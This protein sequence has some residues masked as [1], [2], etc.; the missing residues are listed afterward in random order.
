MERRWWTLLVVCAAMFMLLID[1]N[2]VVVALPNIQ[3]A[4]DAS[5]GSL[6]WMTDA[7]ALTL[8]ALLL[9][10]G[11]LADTYG[12]R[13]AFA[14]GLVVFTGGSLLCGLSPSAPTLVLFRAVQGC[15][16][17]ILSA[18]S[19]ALLAGSFHGRQRGVAFGVWGAVAGAATGLGPVLG[20]VLTDG[21]GWRGIF[22][23]N[24]PVGIA[25]LVI[26]VCRVDESRA[27]RGGRIDWPGVVTL[28]A[29]LFSLVYGLITAS[30]AGWRERGV[31]LWLG[32][33]VCCL[34]AFV[35]VE[36]RVPEPMFSL[37]L[38]RIPSFLGGSVAAFAMNA[39]L[40]AV[41]LYLVLY[42]QNG[43]GGSPL[44]TGV[45]LLV[46]SAFTFV[47]AFAS[48]RLTSRV[49]VRWLI[50]PGLGLVGAG[51]LLMRG[52]TAGSDWTH[53][54]AGLVVSGIGAGMVNPPL[55]STAVGVVPPQWSGMASGANQT[56]RQIGIAVGVAC[57][58]TVFAASL[59]TTLQRRLADIPAVRDR[60]EQVAGAVHRG[61]ADQEVALAPPEARGALADAI[62]TGFADSLNAVL[63]VG[64]LL[65]LVGGALATA[66]IRGRDFAAPQPPR[67]E[68]AHRRSTEVSGGR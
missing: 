48:G 10:A 34:V 60:V 20:G 24:V 19:L 11:S 23:V 43:L 49:P 28:T 5:F 55:A 17:A 68:P 35:V 3:H 7:Y 8:A 66:L 27:P 45:R 22:L 42:L 26:T 59:H 61:V 52:V 63:L 29:G 54:I 40:Y 31:P 21:V 56:F 46:G 62:H 12:R 36:W 18:T 38:L 4:L 15:G 25:A 37:S 64:G 51:L 14:L 16:G 67:G 41:F 65:A 30:D 39:S 2:V 33:A 58:G 13:R 44:A 6:Q 53:L 47:A 57:Y 50:G 32:L 9:T 1:I